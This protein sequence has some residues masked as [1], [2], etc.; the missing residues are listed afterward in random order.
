[1]EVAGLVLGA[2]PMVISS[3]Y[4]YGKAGASGP[5][6]KALKAFL[7]R[8]AEYRTFVAVM[9]QI[10]FPNALNVM[11]RVQ[12]Y[13]ILGEDQHVLAFM[14]AYTSSFNMTGV[15]VSSIKIHTFVMHC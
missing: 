6:H 10:F 1:M 8:R 9:L 11:E 7:G 12:R 5:L 4:A 15:A 2:G 13:V 14:K 3:H